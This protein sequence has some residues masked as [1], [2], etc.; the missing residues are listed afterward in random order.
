MPIFECKV[1]RTVF[2]H[3]LQTKRATEIV[4]VEAKND[5]EAKDKAGHPR[6]WLR[7]AATFGKVDTSSSFL[8]TVGECKRVEDDKVN[9]LR[10][11]EPATP[12]QFHQSPFWGEHDDSRA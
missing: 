12:A 10:L 8:I 9:A 1:S 3:D 2:A 4:Y 11:V 6:N 5:R 7:S